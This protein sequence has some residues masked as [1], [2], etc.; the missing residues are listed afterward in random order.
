VATT[1]LPLCAACVSML[2]V[3]CYRCNYVVCVSR[4]RARCA[5]ACDAVAMSWPTHPFRCSC[6]SFLVLQLAAVLDAP[7][8]WVL[9][10][11]A[12]GVP[13]CSIMFYYL[14][15]M[16]FT[17]H[18]TTQHSAAHGVSMTFTTHHTTQHRLSRC[19]H[20]LHNAPHNATQTAHG[21][22][23]TFTTHHT[24]QHRLLTVSP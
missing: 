23:M 12:H 16:T 18:H 20:D 21:V 14:F 17:T 1:F 8:V 15:S 10:R 9:L 5:A 6:S 4:R 7:S 11:A 24:T 2:C 22:P 19:L 3:S 13:L